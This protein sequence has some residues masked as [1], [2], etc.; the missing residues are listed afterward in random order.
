MGE[1][2][3]VRQFIEEECCYLIEQA[4]RI[5]SV[6]NRLL[7]SL[8]S[9]NPAFFI[10]KVAEVSISCKTNVHKLTLLKNIIFSLDSLS[11]SGASKS[12]KVG[13]L[14]GFMCQHLDSTAKRNKEVN[15]SALAVVSS[16]KNMFKT[17]VVSALV[18]QRD[19]L[20]TKIIELASSNDQSLKND[21]IQYIYQ[22]KQQKQEKTK[23]KQTIP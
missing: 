23:Q 11:L 13:V 17:E 21:V 14:V 5:E 12:K 8:I 22:L 3:K 7:P 2:E 6:G 15:A 18:K 1:K 9:I 4:S 10:E 16:L 20:L 19:T